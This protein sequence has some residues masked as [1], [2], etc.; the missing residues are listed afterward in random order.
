MVILGM[1]SKNKGNAAS[2]EEAATN[3]TA[4]VTTTSNSPAIVNQF[5][6]MFDV[7]SVGEEI[8]SDYLNFE[9]GEYAQEVGEEVKYVFTGI[10]EI[11]NA[12]ENGGE[13]SEAV[14]LVNRDGKR[15]VNADVVVVSTLKRVKEEN[16]P[17]LV[18][19]TFIGK[20]KAANS[21]NKYRDFKIVKY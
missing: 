4:V 18:G 2:S 8:T 17:C 15:F 3:T 1:S 16:R 9:E 12:H 6:S 20:K 21:A 13:T 14:T 7:E 11:D 10:T 5:Q 19:I